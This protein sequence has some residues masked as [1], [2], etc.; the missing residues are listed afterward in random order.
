VKT[1]RVLSYLA[2][3]IPEDLFVLA[4]RTLE[5]RLGL[6]VGL[7]FETRVSGPSPDS[8]PFASDRADLAFVCA[9][10]Y[11]LLKEA[12]S[13]VELLPVA[14]VFADPRLDGRP[15]YFADVLVRAGHPARSFH[16]LRGAVW[17]YNDRYSRSGWQT[18]LARLEELGHAGGPEFFFGSLVR[19]G[20]HLRSLE[21]VSSGQAD[22]AAIDSNTLWLARRR[23]PE[24]S[25][26]LRIIESWGP[27]P[28]QPLLVR[29]G[30]PGSLK[31]RIAEV[32]LTLHEDSR[33]RASLAESGVRRFAPVAESAYATVR[34][35]GVPGAARSSS[36]VGSSLAAPPRNPMLSTGPER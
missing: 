33:A 8:D 22:A 27:M 13:P 28:I 30:L 15:V 2:P 12:G 24:R 34:P 3:S 20:S 1:L 4:A 5:S 17:S 14:P 6:A 16:D 10:S 7:A 21:L 18:M 25:A 23:D 19:A 32:L 35:I 29:A 36:F 11:P 9:P 26:R 31:K